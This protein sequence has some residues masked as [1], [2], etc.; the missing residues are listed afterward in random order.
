MDGGGGEGVCLLVFF[1]PW[2][3]LLSFYIYTIQP[4]GLPPC[5]FP[6]PV[7]FTSHPPLSQS[8]AS[9]LFLQCY[10]SFFL[11]PIPF[12]VFPSLLPCST[13]PSTILPLVYCPSPLS[14]APLPVSFPSI[15]LQVSLCHSSSTSVPFSHP[16]WLLSTVGPTYGSGC[17]SRFSSCSRNQWAKRVCGSWGWMLGHSFGV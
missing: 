6:L 10:L 17:R 9:S 7:H 16:H 13:L 8:G 15:P 1:F 14:L 11:I 3:P 2:A 5:M 4:P 12:S